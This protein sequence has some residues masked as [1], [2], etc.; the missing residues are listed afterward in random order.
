MFFLLKKFG[1]CTF[2]EVKMRLRNKKDTTRFCAGLYAFYRQMVLEPSGGKVFW[3]IFAA[4]YS[5]AALGSLFFFG[6]S[7]SSSTSAAA[8]SAL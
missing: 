2:F 3:R 1:F 5:C 8:A 6:L 7:K 4:S